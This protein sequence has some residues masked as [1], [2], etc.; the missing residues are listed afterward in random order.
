M[1]D[2]HPAYLDAL[3]TIFGR[4]NFE[5]QPRF[6]YSATTLNLERMRALLADLGNPQQHFH[7]VHVAGTKGKGSVCA[8][9]ASILR[10]AG[11]C[12]GLYTSPH[13]HTF[14]ER[15]RVNGA[16]ISRAE[17][18]TL[19]AHCRPALERIPGVT[20]FELI[21][22]LAL[23]HFAQQGVQ[24]AVLEVGLGGRLDSTNVV[25]PDIT[26][27]TSL[28][29]DHMAVLGDTL[30]QIAHEKAGIIKPGVPLVCAPQAPEA[31][32]VIEATCQE[33]QAPLLLLGRDW[34][35]QA[36]APTFWVQP[37][38]APPSPQTPS[39]TISLAGAHQVVN[40][41]QAVVIAAT[42]RT[43]GVVISEE[44]IRRGLASTR[45]PAR[46]EMLTVGG[47]GRPEI[48]DGRPEIGDRRPEIDDRRPE[49]IRP[50]RTRSLISD[51][52]FPTP[53]RRP[54]IGDWPTIIADGAHN[55]DSAQKLAELLDSVK[56][57][58]GGR[59]ALILGAS[60]DKDI[61]GMLTVLAPVTDLLICTH[62]QHPR[63]VAPQ[64]LAALAGEIMRKKGITTAAPLAAATVD[65]ALAL[66]LDWAS[67][68]DVICLAGSLFIA[69]EGREAWARRHPDHFAPDDWVFEAE[70]LEL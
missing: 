49:S 47:D 28:S 50:P 35:W 67:P 27:I 56:R 48:G 20:T 43:Q 21:T 53:D 11:Y 44:A 40:A 29:Y 12:T 66:A 32:A 5:R 51:L 60:L 36:A 52:Q 65:A 70:A 30:T 6:D 42:L 34:V 54:E 14:R 38:E 37:R 24:W 7:I 13:L 68:A 9:T 15:M 1:N 23:T 63:A 26:A 62:A 18:V 31:L 16:L 58:R 64:E 10:A 61:A 4:V 69:A 55:V 41:G 8:F 45:W 19:V 22:A 39:F 3:H 2:N 59:L 33:R 25:Q 57:A 17:L 46:F